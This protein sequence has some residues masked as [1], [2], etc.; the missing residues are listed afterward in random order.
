MC[1][2]WRHHLA[3]VIEWNRVINT[4]T[5]RLIEIISISD[6]GDLIKKSNA[7]NTTPVSSTMSSPLGTTTTSTA[8][9][10]T[11]TTQSNINL[12]TNFSFD[13]QKIINKMDPNTLVQTWFRFFH[14][15]GNPIDFS[16]PIVIII[17]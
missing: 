6:F 9:S 7:S 10:T 13:I 11:T 15:I 8:A 1:S 3:L 12:D 17:I 5:N 14:I 4:L 16:N 2:N